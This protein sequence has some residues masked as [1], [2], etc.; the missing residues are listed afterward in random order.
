M[1]TPPSICAVGWTLPCP[2]PE[3]LAWPHLTLGL[4]TPI[5]PTHPLPFPQLPQLVQEA[6]YSLVPSPGASTRNL[7]SATE[8]SSRPMH[9]RLSL[10]DKSA[11]AAPPLQPGARSGSGAQTSAPLPAAL[12]SLTATP[13]GGPLLQLSGPELALLLASPARPQGLSPGPLTPFSAFLME[14]DA[15]GEATPGPAPGLTTSHAAAES[16][17]AAPAAAPGPAAGSPPAH[18]PASSPA[19]F[20]DGLLM[21]LS[22][23]EGTGSGAAGPSMTG[24]GPPGAG[25]AAELP[26]PHAL[27]SSLDGSPLALSLAALT[28][29]GQPQ[30]SPSLPGLMSPSVLAATLPDDF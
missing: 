26:P 8:A 28:G 2:P 7:E 1:D 15:R 20:L 19:V 4:P 27:R 11:A 16:R 24:P 10:V 14:H 12:A 5:L 13:P 6:T 29:K 22:F 23:V 25:R 17:A 21:D 18:E 30:F 9:L 3:I